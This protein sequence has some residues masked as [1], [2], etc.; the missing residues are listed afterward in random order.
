[1]KS[2]VIT[3]W[4]IGF[5]KNTKI[6]VKVGDS[7]DKDSILF[8]YLIEETINVDASIF[9]SRIKKEKLEEFNFKWKDKAI[10]EGDLLFETSGVFRKK[11]VSP[12][13]GRFVGLDEFYNIKFEIDSEERKEVKS[14]VKAKIDSIEEDKLV[15][16]F[17]AIEFEGSA[18]VEGK[19]WGMSDLKILNK[20]SELNYSLEGSI[21]F[22]NNLDESFLS[23]AEVVGVAGVVVIG[24]YKDYELENNLPILN[25]E[26]KTW[27]NLKD[28]L[29]KREQLFLN[30]KKNRLLIV[31]E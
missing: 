12:C 16:K 18:L 8:S 2:K 11:I 24:D 28:F 10:K 14:P 23:K 4:V 31:V 29:G 6:L 17:K 20:I 27:N 26:E 7:V 5:P 19:A 22:T 9:F 25:I 13:N 21:I 1:M 15:L 30:S 3:K